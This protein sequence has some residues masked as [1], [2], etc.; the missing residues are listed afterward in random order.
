[1]P[2][3]IRIYATCFWQ[4]DEKLFNVLRNISF[5]EP[6]W[7]NIQ[8]TLSNDFDFVVI[9][10]APNTQHKDFKGRKAVIFL[11]GPPSS[12]HILKH[13]SFEISSYLSVSN[14]FLQPLDQLQKQI[15]Q[16]TELF[17]SVTSELYWLEGHKRRIEFLYVLDQN[18]SEGFDLFG[19]KYSGEF[20][21]LLKSYRGEIPNKLDALISYQ[22]HFSC[23]NSF[24]KNYF[25]E[26]I[27]DP[28]LCETLCFY[29]GCTNIEDYIDERSFIRINISEIESSLEKIIYSI[30]NHSFDKKHKFIIT[31]KKRLLYDLNPINYIWAYFNGKDMKTYFKL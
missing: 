5:Q 3:V 4:S 15:Q 14:W 28:I 31:Q 26:K 16:K 27:I 23:E 30:D 8:F 29:D 11:T 13:H 24:I 21:K 6:I 7:K 17:S 22:Y 9:L 19:R 10:T 2:S 20:F 18:I 1:M 12:P 25:T